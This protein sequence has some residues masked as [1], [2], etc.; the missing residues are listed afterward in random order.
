M[1]N[2][3]HKKFKM[4][5]TVNKNNKIKLQVINIS[6]ITLLYLMIINFFEKSYCANTITLKGEG[7]CIIDKSIGITAGDNNEILEELNL[8]PEEI[9]TYNIQGDSVKNMFK[10]CSG[11]TYIEIST[12]SSFLK[13]I[14]GM[15]DGCIGLTSINLNSFGTSNVF[16]MSRM[17]YNCS[18]LQTIIFDENNDNNF[19]SPS[20]EDIS[21]MFYN[22]SV[23]SLTKENLGKFKTENVIDMSHVFELCTN[24]EKLEFPETFSTSKV[25]NMEYMFS[26]C[27]KL[28]KIEFPDF[29]T[30][31]VKNMNSMFK[32]CKDLNS[33][34]FEKFQTNSLINMGSM[35]QSCSSLV[36]IDLSKFDT[37]SVEYMNDLF[38]DCTK[39]SSIVIQD[40]FTENVINMESM[41]QNCESL[42]EL[43]LNKFYTP[44]LRQ[45]SSIFA[46]CTSVT[47]IDISQFD[48]FQITNFA[49]VFYNCHS[50]EK[51][52]VGHLVTNM[53]SDMSQ[54]FFNCS[55]LTSLDISN[56]NVIRVLKMNSMFQGCSKLSEIILSNVKSEKVMDISHMFDGCVSLSSLN[57]SNFVTSSVKNMNSL[58][59]KCSKLKEL[60]LSLFDTS[61]VLMMNSLFYGCSL[62]TSIKLDSFDT[63]QVLDM[64]YMFYD[65]LNLTSIDLS[66]FDTSKVQKF[67]SMFYNCREFKSLSVINFN[68]QNM[69]SMSSMFHG[70]SFIETLDLSKFDTDNVSHMDDLFF[71][72]SSLIRLDISNFEVKKVISMSYMFYGCKSLTSL[73]LPNLATDLKVMNTEYMFSGCS[74]LTYLDLSGFHTNDVIN[75]DY[76]FSGCT[77]LQ[78]LKLNKWNT[79]KVE[80][81]NYMFSGCAFLTSLDLSYFNTTKLQSIKGMFYGCSSLTSLDLHNFK[82]SLVTSM[83]YMFYK[84]QSLETI[85][86]YDSDNSNT[87]SFTTESVENMR[88]MFAY[89]TNLKQVDLSKSKTPKLVDMSFM[90]TNCENLEL[91]NLSNFTTSKVENMEEIFYKCSNLVYIDLNISDDS[92]L[93]YKNNLLNGTVLNMIFC[94]IKDQMPNFT[95]I[96]DEKNIN[97]TNCS[98]ISCIDNYKDIE[99]VRRKL[100][101]GTNRC[102]ES[103]V[104]EN[105]IEKFHYLSQCYDK[106]PNG[107]FH[108]DEDFECY[109]DSLKPPPC[110]IQKAIIGLDNCTVNKLD[111]KYNDTIEDKILFIDD[112]VKDIKGKQHDFIFADYV[113]KYGMVTNKIFDIIFEVTTLSDKNLYTNLTFINIQDCENLLKINN[114]IDENDELIL[115]KIEYPVD[116]FRIPIIEYKVFTLNRTEL[117]FSD[118]NCMK[119]IYSIPVE[120]NESLVYKFNP[121]SNYNNELC[122]QFT[123]ENNTDIILYDRRQEFNV[124]NFSLCESNCKFINY[125]NKRAEC[126]CPVKSDFN[127]F[128]YIEGASKDNLIFRFHDNNLQS[129]NFGVLKCFKTLFTKDGFNSNYS[130]ILYIIFILGDLAAAAYFCYSD[131]KPLYSN[132]QS[133][134]DRLEKVQENKKFKNKNIKQNIITTSG[135]PPPKIKGEKDEKEENTTSKKQEND[136]ISDSSEKKMDNTS[137]FA[138]KLK[139][140][141]TSLIDSNNIINSGTDR[142]LS[143][144][145][146]EK[147]EN[148]FS[149]EKNEME[150]NML[151]YSEAQKKDRRSCF[152]F[153][154]SFLKTRQLII[155][156]FI[157]DYNSFIVKICFILFV[158]GISL[159]ANTFFFT[160]EILHLYYINNGK[161]TI[162]QSISIHIV[163]IIVS[164]VIASIIKSAMSLLTFTD[165]VIIDIKEVSKISR[166]EKINQALIKVTSK[167]TLFFIINFVVMILCWLYVG[168]FCIVFKN[169]QSYLLVNGVISFLG[170]LILPFFYC[171]LTAAIRMVALNGKNKEFLY[172][173]SQIFELI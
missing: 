135:N 4:N 81:M 82:T 103:C 98:I 3:K 126:E 11:L 127:K 134:A 9:K 88:Y 93:I 26:N 147:D 51:I 105:T 42:T 65:C 71:G 119:F 59:S 64:S 52:E 7:K 168:S 167:S 143:G 41:F 24:F 123:T 99:N 165:V 54:M 120:I 153:Y 95:A 62:L 140:P 44:S 20:V 68:T 109:P 75:M 172:K 131:Y 118:C 111:T 139:V 67:D 125:F 31:N 53:A 27:I 124:D 173:F 100:V 45:M 102:V 35:F 141:T 39:L 18:K 136:L 112:L 55:T 46:G 21:Y 32:N 155:C 117:N 161:A 6:K 13:D 47:S 158:F 66:N 63:S 170:V 25:E 152:E 37:S 171:L 128:L 151:S 97:K 156:T 60:N 113:P 110:T 79:E 36:S 16:N 90:F 30:N 70:C 91:V 87:Y 104:K 40:F 86:F 106:C 150:I 121:D 116:E 2:G 94:I 85:N 19:V 159:C 38:H 133:L 142:Q 10:D 149:S 96:I 34:S 15:F 80:K 69:E 144:L 58:F 154:F 129:T 84:A 76:M 138:P 28:T 166:E 72:C 146:K 1:N 61:K 29:V 114:N 137:K 14:S 78:E 108:F 8:T 5:E 148:V 122:Y 22:C 162:S 33:I 73:I 74:S 56:F 115:L 130:S 157:T 101:N 160:D 107:T 17:F 132:I 77:Y 57:L 169:T 145:N 83:A 164:T 23:L 89:C 48:T 92:Q 12:S 163:S 50:L 49:N 43:N